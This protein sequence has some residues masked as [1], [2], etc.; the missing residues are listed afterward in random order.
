MRVLI[1]G[2]EK[3]M[4]V[5]LVKYAFIRESMPILVAVLLSLGSGTGFCEP[6]IKKSPKLQT[7]K[8][9]SNETVLLRRPNFYGA[10]MYPGQMTF[11][12][13]PMDGHVPFDQIQHLPVGYF[14]R[15]GKG[16]ID[17]QSA[18]ILMPPEFRSL[19]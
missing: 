3:D 13:R 5:S 16:D 9:Q 11:H 6:E 15:T 10:S 12:V 8:A 1:D 7:N 4:K 19:F 18:Y 17:S 14:P 2:D